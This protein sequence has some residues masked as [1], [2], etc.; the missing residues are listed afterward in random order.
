MLTVVGESSR[1]LGFEPRVAFVG[2]VDQPLPPHLRTDV[3]ATLRESLSNVIRHARASA[4][5]VLVYWD[6]EDQQLTL[7]V[8]DDG[9]GI[10][11]TGSQGNGLRNTAARARAARGWSRVER[12]AKAGTSFIWTV[13][14]PGM[15]DQAA[16]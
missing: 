11:P 3:L 9:T 10:N 2:P 12:R 5:D 7:Q 13:P 15:S 8:D 6:L 14:V 16:T 4:V 1:I